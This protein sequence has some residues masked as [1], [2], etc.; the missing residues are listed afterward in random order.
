MLDNMTSN[1]FAEWQA[2]DQ[3]TPFG[4][5]ADTARFAIQQANILN[6]PHFV[7]KSK[8]PCK[9]ADFMPMREQPKQQTIEEQAAILDRLG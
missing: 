3:I 6:A 9:A 5:L 4:A 1:Q 7:D 2:F 8:K